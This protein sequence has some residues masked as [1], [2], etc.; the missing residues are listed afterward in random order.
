M[1]PSV[2]IQ[3]LPSEWGQTGSCYLMGNLL[4]ASLPQNNLSCIPT[5]PDIFFFSH[6]N[7]YY[8]F[9]TGPDSWFDLLSSAKYLELCLVHLNC[10]K[11]SV[12]LLNEIWILMVKSFRKPSKPSRYIFLWF[13]NG[14]WDISKTFSKITFVPSYANLRFLIWRCLM[15]HRSIFPRE[16]INFGKFDFQF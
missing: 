15:C 10:W 14:I 9:F 4:L 8:A 6:L 16:D 2:L 3:T 1:Q 11:T 5:F 7:T 12:K 13:F